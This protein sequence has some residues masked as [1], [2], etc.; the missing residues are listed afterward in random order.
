METSD[1]KLDY[2]GVRFYGRNDL[3]NHW[4]VK[5]AET[6]LNSFDPNKTYE[7]INEIIE[8]YNVQE[9]INSGIVLETWT[10]EQYQNYK[11]KVSLF[12]AIIGKFFS[13][14]KDENFLETISSVSLL[15]RNNF[16]ALFVRFRT[17]KRISADIFKAYLQFPD[18]VLDKILEHKDLVRHYGIQLAD[19]MRT[20]DQTA[21]ILVSKYL[22]KN[23]ANYYI[24]EEFEPKEC[25]LIFQRYIESEQVNPNVLH[26][27]HKGQS[28][29][30]CPISDR[31]RLKAKHAAEQFWKNPKETIVSTGH[32]VGV[33]VGFA[34][35]C[36][37]VEVKK[38]GSTWHL[39]YDINWLEDCLDYP[40]IL[41]NFTYLFEMFD[42]HF[43]S[44]LVSVRSEISALENAITVQGR[45]F[46]PKG[47]QF[48]VKNIASVA[49]TTL[50]YEFLKKHNI[51]LEEVFKWFFETYLPEEF[52]VYGFYMILSSPSSTYVEKCR[53][54]A[55]E[56]DG[57]LKK[58]RM[59]V[60]DG[61]IDRELFEMSTEHM[62]IGNIPSL[63]SCKYAYP[64]SIEVNHEMWALFS[65]QTALAHIEKT[66]SKYHT[67][68]ELLI[69]EKVYLSDFEEWQQKEIQWL[70]QRGVISISADG[71]I[72]LVPEKRWVLKDLYEHDVVCVHTS[73]FRPVLEEMISAGDLRVESKLF[74][75]PE[76]D[77]L[78]Y[79]LN[80]SEFSDGLELRNKY[81]HA[82]YPK[83]ENE[84]RTDYMTLL[85]LMVLIITKINDEFCTLDSLKRR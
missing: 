71:S 81:I 79:M 54:L 30:E 57:V 59:F 50:Y 23:E 49:Q 26:L 6:V 51:N 46:Y 70:N 39:T 3:A 7:N 68:D 9:L 76:R 60:E 13:Q 32:G 45:K 77:Y 8:L 63:I 74:T 43:R 4:E 22:E 56:M 41:N 72:A 16:W 36:N 64:K 75:E 66:K 14:I 31:L 19:V 82:T 2:D 84:Q 85:K 24:P 67:L 34:D 55:S 69:N 61:E 48:D 73:R 47:I 53:S 17:Y 1:S 15:Y 29:R 37:V 65:N 78:N 44:S 20:S 21:R 27:I 62:V 18:T 12:T 38:D 58:F 42:V 80:K 40:T 83:D 25:E 5:K 52:G 11:D 35:Q 10:Q 33:S 28:T